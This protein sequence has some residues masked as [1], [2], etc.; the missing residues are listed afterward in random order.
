MIDSF[1]W[2]NKLD[3]RQYNANK[4]RL[5]HDQQIRQTSAQH[6]YCFDFKMA[7]KLYI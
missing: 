1:L 6:V 4:K 5:Q 7:V 2:L 3:N